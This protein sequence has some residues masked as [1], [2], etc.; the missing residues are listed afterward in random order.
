M[1]ENL[2]KY[3]N[4]SGPILI[5]GETGVGKSTIAQKLHRA[6]LRNGRFV[7]V[8]IGGISSDLLNS[9]L[10]GHLKGSFT[11]AVYD[12]I[13]HAE[14]ARDGTLFLDEIGEI[15]M[16]MQKKLLVFL[17]QNEFYPVGSTRPVSFKGKLLMATN[18]DLKQKVREG[19]FREDLFF[20]IAGAQLKLPPLRSRHN[21]KQLIIDEIESYCAYYEKRKSLSQSLLKKLCAYDWPGNHRELK[22]I[23]EYL[24]YFGNQRLEEKDLPDWFSFDNTASISKQSDEFPIVYRDALE[25][26]ESAYLEQVLN[27]FHGK[28]NQTAR[29]INMSKVTLIKKIRKYQIDLGRYEF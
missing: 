25:V 5:I 10:F 18:Q 12:K 28:V 14:Q 4:F 8:N 24:A 26:F 19:L 11:G 22:N 2:E 1:I 9:E 27:R 23:A 16:E 15:S 13:G 7:Q 21:K 6:S 3:A 29:V 17:D 20:R